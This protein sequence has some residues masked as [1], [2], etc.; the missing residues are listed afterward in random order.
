MGRAVVGPGP[1]QIFESV[2]SCWA[3]PAAIL[4]SHVKQQAEWQIIN[5]IVCQSRPAVPCLLYIALGASAVAASF[6]NCT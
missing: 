5:G 3:L 4:N 6:H 1:A 2:G